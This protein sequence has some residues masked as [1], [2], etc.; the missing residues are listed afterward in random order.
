MKDLVVIARLEI[1][2][3]SGFSDGSV[4]ITTN[5]EYEDWDVGSWR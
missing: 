1:A 4:K 3:S 5:L 2:D